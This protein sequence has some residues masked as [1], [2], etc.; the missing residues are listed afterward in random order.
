VL[1]TFSARS[2]SVMTVTEPPGA[3]VTVIETEWSSDW[4]LPLI[5]LMSWRLRRGG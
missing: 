3:T 1:S 2:I 4:A 5:S